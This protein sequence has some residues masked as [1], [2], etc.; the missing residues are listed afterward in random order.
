MVN[1]KRDQ[2]W[3]LTVAVL[4]VEGPVGRVL[5]QQVLHDHILARH[6]AHYSWTVLLELQEL[7]RTPPLL[8]IAVK[9]A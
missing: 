7:D 6:D 3:A 5:K 2:Q 9:C 1:R 8:A 4:R